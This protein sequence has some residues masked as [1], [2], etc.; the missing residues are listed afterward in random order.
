MGLARETQ[1]KAED[2]TLRAADAGREVRIGPFQNIST[3]PGL[4]L[5]RLSGFASPESGADPTPVSAARPPQTF[6]T[7]SRGNF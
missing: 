3:L 2:T 6:A 1:H 5:Y 7:T 4:A